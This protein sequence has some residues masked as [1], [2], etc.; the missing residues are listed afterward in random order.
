LKNTLADLLVLEKRIND[1]KDWISK[2]EKMQ[3]RNEVDLQILTVI[4]FLVRS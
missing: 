4:F 1:I 2:E 3:E